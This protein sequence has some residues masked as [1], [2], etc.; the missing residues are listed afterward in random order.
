MGRK[1]KCCCSPFFPIE[2]EFFNSGNFAEMFKMLLNLMSSF[3]C[4]CIV[5]YTK[6][7]YIRR[8]DFEKVEKGYQLIQL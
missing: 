2:K 7:T 1:T 6:Y 4:Y 5:F 3:W 8:M